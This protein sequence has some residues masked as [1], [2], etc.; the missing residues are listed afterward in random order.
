MNER[1]NITRIRGGKWLAKHNTVKLLEDSR[2][3]KLDDLGNGDAVLDA[4]PKTQSTKERG[5]KAE[6]RYNE[7]LL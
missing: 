6:L 5:E 4:T 7:K 1:V 3:E 2:G